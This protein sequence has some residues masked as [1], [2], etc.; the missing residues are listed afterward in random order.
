MKNIVA[1]LYACLAFTVVPASGEFADLRTF[2]DPQI[3][4]SGKVQ[5][6]DYK[7][8]EDRVYRVG[9][10][11]IDAPAEIV[12]SI[13]KDPEKLGD[14]MTYLTYQKVRSPADSRQ[15]EVSGEM[16]IEGRYAME[17][18]PAQYTICMNFDS[19]GMWRKW[20]TLTSEEV[21]SYNRSGMGVLH[22]SGLI[23]EMSG[24]D[25]AESLDRTS[26]TVYYYALDLDSTIPLPEHINRGI[27][28]AVFSR[29]M[30]LVKKIAESRA[31]GA[32]QD[33]ED[34]GMENQN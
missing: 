9:A 27:H 14:A 26:R 28:E 3:I 17:F 12:W 11:L 4:G 34:S 16:I 18:F 2:L 30:A 25:H 6:F 24:F 8:K 5:L 29:H 20:R 10:V 23:R 22:T 19:P 21:D 1:M 7:T 13:L 33:A 15:Q 31:A 32:E